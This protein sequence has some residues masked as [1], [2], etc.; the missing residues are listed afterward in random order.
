MPGWVRRL[1]AAYS[2]NMLVALAQGIVHAVARE[3]IR[4]SADGPDLLSELFKNFGIALVPFVLT[5]A[6]CGHWWYVVIHQQVVVEAAKARAI[7]CACSSWAARP[8]PQPAAPRTDRSFYVSFAIACVV[9]AVACRAL[10]L[11]DDA[12]RFEVLKL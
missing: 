5:A 7:G 10:L 3:A 4:T 1:A 12:E 11:A 2:R 6:R 8:Q 9:A